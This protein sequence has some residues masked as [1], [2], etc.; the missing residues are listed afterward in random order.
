MVS[1]STGER[2]LAARAD[3]DRFISAE[4]IADLRKVL[5][6]DQSAPA[7]SFDAT[8]AT[9]LADYADALSGFIRIADDRP[10]AGELRSALED[11]FQLDG[12][13]PSAQ[14]ELQDNIEALV[15]AVT[16]K[17]IDEAIDNLLAGLDLSDDDARAQADVAIRSIRNA[18]TRGDLASA[19][20]QA[21]T[22][23]TSAVGAA[24]AREVL[25]RQQR[26][27]QARQELNRMYDDLFG[28]DTAERRVVADIQSR[29]DNGTATDEDRDTLD[30]MI[31]DARR[32]QSLLR[33]GVVGT[34]TP[35]QSAIADAA[36]ADTL[37]RVDTLRDEITETT[38]PSAPSVTANAVVND[39]AALLGLD[40][41]VQ[42]VA[43]FN[44]D[45][46]NQANLPNSLDSLRAVAANPNSNLSSVIST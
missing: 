19:V 7:S 5:G 33:Q 43:Y 10:T 39:E 17:E 32:S 37:R 14:T 23:L 2:G 46:S 9:A 29:I 3:L 36:V 26:I 38:A 44:P 13:I 27:E 34:P 6:L 21:S 40:E 20:S 8:N 41:P 24:Q 16:S 4:E 11:V 18:T 15:D 45:D 28:K 42:Q 31:A 35:Q 12:F 1:I 22:L 25:E 30:Q